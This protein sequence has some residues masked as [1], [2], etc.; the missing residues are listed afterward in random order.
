MKSD[1]GNITVYIFIFNVAHIENQMVNRPSFNSCSIER[2]WKVM[3]EDIRSNVFLPSA[4]IF[5][6]AING[7]F[8]VT[9]PK[10]AQSHRGRSND[11]FQMIKTVPSS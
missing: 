3:N 9:L 11:D 2:L 5:R 4:K 8:D 10:I 1:C 6:D 7:F